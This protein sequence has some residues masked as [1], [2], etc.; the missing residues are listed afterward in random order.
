MFIVIC[1]KT[2]NLPVI[3]SPN[4]LTALGNKN[5]GGRAFLRKSSRPSRNSGTIRLTDSAFLCG[6]KQIS[7]FLR[8]L[9]YIVS[10]LTF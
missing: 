1:I 5:S 8:E 9:D 10:Y 3:Q 6:G 4:I 2:S 7:G